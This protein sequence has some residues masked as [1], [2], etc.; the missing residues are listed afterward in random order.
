MELIKKYFP[1]LSE[2]QEASFDALLELYKDWNSKINVISRKDIDQ[3]Y[4]RHVLHSL[5]IAKWIE[6]KPK[7]RILDVGCGGGFPGIPLAILFPEVSFHLV[8][9]VNKK[10]TVVKAV[11]E[12]IGL[13]NIQTTHTRVEEV[14]DRYDFVVTRAVA[15]LDKLM[16][17]SRKN[18]STRHRNAFP[19]GLI[20]LK[21]GDL[22]AE[23]GVV[24]KKDYVEQVSIGDYFE[25]DFFD[26]KFL[27]YVQG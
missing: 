21:G 19:N 12:G 27:I 2:D 7:T 17:W 25:E 14:K 6:F 11:A 23:L 9:S 18:I 20:A 13:K 10:L 3:L 1:E 16:I 24:K 4:L 8:D 22:R 26:E 5:A 15:K